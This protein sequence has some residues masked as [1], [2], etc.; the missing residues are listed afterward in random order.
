MSPIGRILIVVNLLLAAAFLGWASKTLQVSQNWK[1]QYETLEDESA[2]TVEDLE[3][4]ISSVNAQLDEQRRAAAEA[5]QR[6]DDKAVEAQTLQAQLNDAEADNDALRGEIQTMNSRLTDLARSVDSATERAA[7]AEA[8]AREAVLA[9]E[10]AEDAQREAELQM[11]DAQ[12]QVATLQQSLAA[13]EAG[14]AAL[15]AELAQ[16]E[17]KLGTVA[18]LTGID[19]SKID[20]VPP[21]D[22]VVIAAKMELEPGFVSIDAGSRD[23]VQ[24]GTVFDIYRGA[25][26]KG[27]VRVVEV[28]EGA[29]SAVV[30]TL[31]DGTQIMTGDNATT[32][33]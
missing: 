3:S 12:D 23:G 31:V 20:D 25:T 32:T 30:T 13:A 16:A 14:A 19:I 10:E 11:R 27:Q 22:K 1:D 8:D 26:Y 28:S 24:R 18:W 4:Q 9:R 2:A 17:N 6:A 5:S 7:A 15:A 21:L 33:L 29:C